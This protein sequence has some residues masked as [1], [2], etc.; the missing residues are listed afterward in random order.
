LSTRLYVSNLSTSATLSSVRQFFGACGE[1]VDV[2]FVAERNPGRRPSS[3]YVTMATRGAAEQ[4]VS[5][6]HSRLLHDRSVMVS[7]AHGGDNNDRPERKPK[8]SPAAVAIAQQ[9][10]DRHGMTYELDCLGLS[11]TLRFF[12]PPEVGEGEHR[13]VAHTSQAPQLV[14]EATAHTRELALAAVADAWRQLPAEQAA[15]VLDWALVVTALQAV[16]AV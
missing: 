16:R 11:L 10:R 7:L 14:V 13:V 4:A 8:A 3:A 9:Y 6:L 15:P 2:E 5:K 1:V 12:F